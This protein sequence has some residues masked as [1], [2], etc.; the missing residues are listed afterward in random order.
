MIIDLFQDTL[1]LRHNTLSLRHNPELRTGEDFSHLREP[2]IVIS[3]CIE[4]KGRFKDNFDGSLALMNDAFKQIEKEELIVRRV[5]MHDG[6][7][8]NWNMFLES[9][10]YPNFLDVDD[11]SDED[12][13]R[14]QIGRLWT[15]GIYRIDHYG[16][17]E[18]I[19]CSN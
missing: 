3:G 12:K 8:Y 11:I 6:T 1:S 10:N 15:A 19:C 18:F 9:I 17:G 2:R 5:Y 14:G 4:I 13:E 16:Y 7:L